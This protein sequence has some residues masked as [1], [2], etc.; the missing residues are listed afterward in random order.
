MPQAR[1]VTERAFG[2]SENN[3][4]P[5][6]KRKRFGRGKRRPVILANRTTVFGDVCFR[7]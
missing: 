7:W 4:K 1:Q 2:S 6:R 3:A 5:R